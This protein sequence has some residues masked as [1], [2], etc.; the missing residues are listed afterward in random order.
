MTVLKIK[1]DI[2]FLSL[3]SLRIVRRLSAFHSEHC[4]SEN[5]NIR[6]IHSNTLIPSIINWVHHLSPAFGG[7]SLRKEKASAFVFFRMYSRTQ[8]LNTNSKS[9]DS[10]KGAILSLKS[11]HILLLPPSLLS[12][13]PLTTSRHQQTSRQAALS[14]AL[15]ISRPLAI[16]EP[17]AN[18]IVLST[19]LLF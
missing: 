5:Q 10:L 13:L 17:V 12:T 8:N 11:V 14:T 16:S 3:V 18:S 9:R 19:W 7:C 1:K 2:F 15:A 6:K 4:Q